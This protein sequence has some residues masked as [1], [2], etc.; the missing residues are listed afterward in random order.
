VVK[1]PEINHESREIHEIICHALIRIEDKR[2]MGQRR[3]AHKSQLTTNY[4]NNTNKSLLIRVI[5]VIRGKNQ[6]A[7]ST[8]TAIM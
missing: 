1:I 8:K 6:Y 4:T 5:S 3:F 2:I 7:K